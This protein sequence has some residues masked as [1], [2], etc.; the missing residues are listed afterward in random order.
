MQKLLTTNEVAR[1][2]NVPRQTL[3]KAIA[4]GRLTPDAELE[5]SF[6]FREDRLHEVVAVLR[7]LFD[8]KVQKLQ[9]IIRAANPEKL[10]A[11]IAKHQLQET[12]T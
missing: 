7:V 5:K 8:E 9:D 10:R 6:L 11:F 12:Q 1:R 4:T 3:I 2:L